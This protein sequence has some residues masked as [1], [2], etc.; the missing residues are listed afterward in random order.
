M[1]KF[2]IFIFIMVIHNCVLYAQNERKILHN[3]YKVWVDTGRSTKPAYLATISDSAIYTS[4]YPVSYMP[5]LVNKTFYSAVRYTVI[6]KVRVIKKGSAV[7]GLLTGAVAGVFV[8]AMIGLADGEDEH[9]FICFSP[10][11]KALILELPS[12]R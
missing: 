5:N 1:I 7:K 6:N 4:P 10:G 11:E 2:F 9:C 3:I 12:E 8:G